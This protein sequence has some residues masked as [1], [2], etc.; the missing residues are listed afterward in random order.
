[1]N[2]P[3]FLHYGQ[4]HRSLPFEQFPEYIQSSLF[5][6]VKPSYE[7]PPY[8][9]ELVA[10]YLVA[11][12]KVIEIPKIH[13][14]Y[15]AVDLMDPTREVVRTRTYWL[16]EKSFLKEAVVTAEMVRQH[17]KDRV[18]QWSQDHYD[19]DEAEIL[20]SDQWH[21]RPSI[22]DREVRHSVG[23]GF[24]LDIGL[25]E[26]TARPGS[27]LRPLTTHY[28]RPPGEEFRECPPYENWKTL[29]TANDFADF[30]NFTSWDIMLEPNRDSWLVLWERPVRE[31]SARQGAFPW[32]EEMREAK[33]PVPQ[34]RFAIFEDPK[35]GERVFPN[36]LVVCDGTERE[37][38]SMEMMWSI[39]KGFVG[40]DT[41]WEPVEDH[42]LELAE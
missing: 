17:C 7:G 20:H 21:I 32:L 29:E 24:K 11:D 10:S 37:K 16:H 12:D 4:F 1:M 15:T 2:S 3:H 31:L 34:Y 40:W 36:E 27:D 13:V 25:Q 6:H 14:G 30:F 33:E 23:E 38:A 26:W 18:V 41:D 5:R 35:T 19:D 9:V 42:E 39:K 8:L 28:F 22:T